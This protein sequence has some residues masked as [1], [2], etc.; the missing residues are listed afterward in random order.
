VLLSKIVALMPAR[1][2]A[3]VLGLTLRALLRWVDLVIVLDHRSTDK[4]STILQD[5]VCSED[6]PVVI[7]TEAKPVW[8]EMRHRQRLLDEARRFGATHIVM[9]DADE[10]LTGNLV[11]GMRA[12]VLACPP[13]TVMQIPW[14]QLRG[15]IS[16]HHS[17]GQWAEQDVSMAFVDHPELG[18]AA[19]DGY[20][21]HHRHPMGREVIP[22]QPLGPAFIGRRMG[23]LMHLQMVSDRRLRTKQALYVMQETVRWPGRMTPRQLNEMYGPT[24]YGGQRSDLKAL[25]PVRPEWWAGYED[26]MQ[27]LD[28]DA[29]PWQAAE[30][31]RLMQEHGKQTFAGLDLFGV[32]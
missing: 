17:V 14:I 22:Y 28:V 11:A 10:I 30:C 18:W 20:D 8:E 6:C 16:E 2:E 3:W 32:V 7:L 4:S 15:S 21:F 13:G 27:Y 5:I 24:V 26:L 23:G 25:A 12:R 9:V 19:R 29:E 1:N 31:H